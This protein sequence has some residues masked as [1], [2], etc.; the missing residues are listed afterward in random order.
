M[1]SVDNLQNNDITSHG[2][3]CFSCFDML[4]S[5]SFIMTVVLLQWEF[6]RFSLHNTIYKTHSN[7]SDAS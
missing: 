1:Y 4:K 3:E 7:I 5:Q 2:G 6:R